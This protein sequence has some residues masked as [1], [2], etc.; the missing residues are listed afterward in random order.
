MAAD[1]TVPAKGVA[2]RPVPKN[3]LP[4]SRPPGRLPPVR[5]GPPR[6]SLPKT[7]K[8]RRAKLKIGMPKEAVLVAW[9]YPP[10]HTTP[11]LESKVCTYWLSRIPNQIKKIHFDSHG[12]TVRFPR[13]NREPDDL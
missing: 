12:K 9:R 11:S 1:Q 5:N 4:I 3:R 7:P 10:K 6:P 2:Q 8:P 13:E